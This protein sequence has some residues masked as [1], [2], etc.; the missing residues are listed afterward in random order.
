M[1]KRILCF[2]D[3]NTYGYDP[4]GGRYD[5]SIRWPMAMQSRLGGGYT[6]IEEG[7]NGRTAVYDD[8]VEGGYKSGLAYL[9]PCIMT[10]NPLDLI[11][12]MLGTN[13][14]KSRFGLNAYT[15]AQCQERLIEACRAYGETENG[16]DPEILLVSPAHVGDWIADTWLGP[17]FGTASIETS[18]HLSKEYA[19][20][21][22]IHGCHFFDAAPVV[23]LA[24]E[25]ALHFTVRGQIALAEA[26][27]QK[28]FEIFR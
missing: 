22:E 16:G 27:T 9:P 15:I 4:N 25:D 19:R 26:M 7:L 11:I 5:E 18:R 17:I 1:K 14:L 24:R 2:G 23:E 12:I 6:V 13:D 3:S 28:A 8:P 10:H 20:V 21:A